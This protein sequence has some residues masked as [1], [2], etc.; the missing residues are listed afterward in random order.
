MPCLLL[1][2]ICQDEIGNLDGTSENYFIKFLIVPSGNNMGFRANNG[3]KNALP[4][5]DLSFAF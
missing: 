1:K 5:K 3:L 2:E 4:P